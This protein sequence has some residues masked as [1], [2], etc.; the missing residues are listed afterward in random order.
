MKDKEESVQDVVRGLEG[1]EMLNQWELTLVRDL[2]AKAQAML[3][4][5]KEKDGPARPPAEGG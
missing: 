2:K 4:P 3:R 1:L 5:S